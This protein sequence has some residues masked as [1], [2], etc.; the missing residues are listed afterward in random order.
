MTNC[1]LKTRCSRCCIETNMILTKKDIETIQQLGYALDFF[2]LEEN[3]WLQLKN[4]QGRCVFHNGTVC[5]IYDKRP[6][7]CQLYPI[8]YDKDHQKAILD[9]DCP[10]QHCFKLAKEKSIELHR[11]IRVLEK[12]RAKRKKEKRHH[13]RSSLYHSG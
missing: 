13:K 11:L 9:S 7:G 1:C 10:E 12:E 3:S 4:N 8:V 6:K 5:T 2:V